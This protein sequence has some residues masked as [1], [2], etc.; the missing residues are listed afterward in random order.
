MTRALPP[1]ATLATLLVIAGDVM[2]FAGLLFAFWALRLGTP[3]WPPPLQ[4]RLPLAVTAVNTLVLLASAAAMID[5]V[6]GLGRRSR[7]RMLRGLATAALLGG[8]F[9]AV[10][11][12]EWSRLIAFGV[13]VTSGVFGALF[14]TLIGAHAVHV[15]A[16]LAWL[17]TTLVLAW[18]GRFADG[19]GAG[20]RACALYWCF[21]VALW[22]LLYLSVY[23]V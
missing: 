12:Y 20:L 14:Y 13:T 9:L 18:R 8:L 3:A 10:Q 6:R 7:P 19:P 11:G 17:G 22:P 23:L 21:V 2:L 4:P 1:A 5:A 16:A 15:V